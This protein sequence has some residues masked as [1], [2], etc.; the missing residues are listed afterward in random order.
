[1]SA[2]WL[3]HVLPEH[4]ARRQPD[5]NV[6]DA[7]RLGERLVFGFRA[8]SASGPGPSVRP[9]LL[10]FLAREVG[11][12][13]VLERQADVRPAGPEHKSAAAPAPEATS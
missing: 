9:G 1:M 12:E 2:I 4:A 13:N 3:D 6:P 8:Q 11:H 10:V 7:N 5:E